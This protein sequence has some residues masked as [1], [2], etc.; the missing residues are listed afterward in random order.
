M[1]NL[2]R[3]FAENPIAAN[4]LMIL[5]LVGGF[6]S[7]PRLGKEV[8]PSIP[9][10]MV[11]VE[12]AYPG[13]GPSEVEELVTRRIEDAVSTVEGIKEISSFSQQSRS[14]V[15]VEGDA[16]V[17]IQRLLADVKSAVDS[18]ITLPAETERPLVREMR[19]TIEAIDV[20]IV[21]D[22][23]EQTLK[24]YAE[25]VRD[26]LALIQGV[27]K[28][29]LEAI[30]SNEMSIEI[31]DAQLRRFNLSFDD[32]VSAVRNSSLNLP[33]GTI[34]AAS[35]DIQVQTRGQAYTATDYEELV[36][37][38][39]PD[40]TIVRIRDV[41]IVTDGFEEFDLYAD[42]DGVRG[43]SVEVAT[44]GER[45]DL[46]AVT[47]R[48][49][50]YVA[51]AQKT[52]PDGITITTWRDR[53]EAFE[54]RM[55]LLVSNAVQGL[56][57][58]FIVLML[59]LRPI[60]AF[61]VAAGIGVAFMGAIWLMPPTGT[62]LNMV[63]MFAYLMI[64]GIVVDDA[65]ISG[66]SIYTE[67]KAGLKGTSGAIAGAQRV[68]GPVVFAVL[69]TMVF[70]AAMLFLPGSGAAF[71]RPIAMV[72]LLTLTFSLI[73][74]LLILPAHLAH[75]G[76]EKKSNN[77]IGRFRQ[78]FAEGLMNFASQTYRPLLEKSVRA[79]R[80]TL[81]AFFSLFLLLVVYYA[82]GGVR[83]S[84]FPEINAD[85]LV[86]RATLESG[87]PFSQTR[88]VSNAINEGLERIE[89]MDIALN[90]N[91]ESV[92]GRTMRWS[93]RNNSVVVL[94][95]DDPSYS[96]D[97]CALADAWRR[98]LE[99]LPPLKEFRLNCTFSGDN[100]DISLN[101][102]A[103]DNEQFTTVIELLKERLR[104]YPGVIDIESSMEASRDEI[105]IRLK[106]QAEILGLTL[107][108][109]ARQV[110]QSFYGEE[111]Q[112]IPRGNEDVRVMVRY[113]EEARRTINTLSSMYV[114]T[115]SGIEVPF[116]TVAEAIVVPGYT[117]IQRIDRRRAATITAKVLEDTSDPTLIV[118][119]ILT[120]YVPQWRANYPDTSVDRSGQMRD[121]EEFQSAFV[122]LIVTAVLIN[123]ML[124]SIAFKSYSQPILIASAIPFGFIGALIGHIL[125]GINM[126]MFSALGILA[127]AGIVVNDNLVLVDR[128]NQLYRGGKDLYESVVQGGVDRFRPIVLTSI[129]TFVGL[130]PILLFEHSPQAQFLKPMVVSLAFGVIAATLVTLIFTPAL[131]ILLVRIKQRVHRVKAWINEV[132]YDESNVRR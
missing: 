45:P 37:R 38:A 16:G 109:I 130:A 21:G 14:R 2:I 86:A 99:D 103:T 22:V 25:R 50:E 19:F 32:V 66:E 87:A 129:T 89:Q 118:D 55:N 74:S 88:E 107:R 108:S 69:S 67:Q 113:P 79:K 116:S 33:A 68:A 105:E 104:A 12:T 124:M 131:Y 61:W 82:T 24:T 73:E 60:L 29:D 62:T 112:R 51:D 35:G 84:F 8:F 78:R 72:V 9:L 5:I 76:E 34:R 95:I 4:L 119:E 27:S 101:V 85:A 75:V 122:A 28:V 46:P 36:V 90:E 48:I 31:S 98:E 17:D 63:S 117:T 114:R 13:A 26:D 41:A 1:R 11:V 15:Q 52:L 20:L 102:T 3:W 40:G 64:L 71:Q 91:G 30:R 120:D 23:P 39:Q 7:M 70:F 111:A 115:P 127:V 81:T 10:N 18:V 123:L 56:I 80:V 96:V 100:P 57:L 94:E 54:G 42:V 49:R 65:I 83:T 6:M 121:Q 126:T 92:L 47:A 77:P 128:I 125:L 44:G 59:F 93:W 43:A 106:P 53:S 110:R 58:V 97:T 132:E